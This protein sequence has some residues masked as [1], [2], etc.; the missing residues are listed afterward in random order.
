MGRHKI[1]RTKCHGCS[2]PMG[3]EAVPVKITE[4]TGEVSVF[5]GK[6]D[7][8]WICP[9]CRQEPSKLKAAR[10]AAGLPAEPRVSRF[11]EDEEEQLE[12][13]G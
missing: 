9:T 4:L 12:Q 6:E 5:Y 7:A 11:E 13:E 1:I 3:F 10:L 8:P 2:L